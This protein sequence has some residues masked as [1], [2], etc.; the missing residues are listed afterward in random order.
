MNSRSIGRTARMTP[1]TIDAEDPS[2]SFF[3]G[4][5][6][7]PALLARRAELTPWA[8]AYFVQHKK[9]AWEAITWSEAHERVVALAAGLAQRGLRP[10]SRV[11]I[12]AA[13]SLDW[14]IAQMATLECG[15]IVIGIDP[16]YPDL[17]INELVKELRLTFLLAQDL[18]TLNRIPLTTRLGLQFIALFHHE[19]ESP[20]PDFL[21]LGQLLPPSPRE[22]TQ[23]R[24]QIA[25]ATAPAL[26]VFSSGSTGRP[27][28]ILYTHA[29]IVHACRCILELYPELAREA[30]LVCW[31]PLANLF[32]RMINFCATAKGATTYIVSDPRN[33]MDV[34]PVAKPEVLM[35]VPRFCERVHAGIMQTLQRRPRVARMVE[36]AIKLGSEVRHAQA[37]NLPISPTRRLA[38]TLADR[39]VLS[40]L[41]APFGGKL[42][43]IVSGSAPM[44]R[45]LLDR[46]E[47]IGIPVLE[48]YGATENLVP[49]A[50]NRLMQRKS[51]TVGKPVGDNEV[52]IDADGKVEVRGFGVFLPTLAENVARASAVGKDGFLSTGD[53]G[54]RDQEGFLS[55]RGRSGEAFKNSQGRWVSLPIIEAALRTITGVE[56]A[57]VMRIAGDRLVGVLGFAPD[58]RARAG[59]DSTL[60]LEPILRAQLAH[61][62]QALPAAMRPIAYI[63]VCTGF[64]LAGGELTTNLKLRRAAI[65]KRVSAELG[66]LIAESEGDDGN[67]RGQIRLTFA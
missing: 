39:L 29:Q 44:P 3:A 4:V 9:G 64:S 17:L 20:H 50:A 31:L 16:Y 63:V 37:E 59:A 18:V 57:A 24:E 8:P 13:T 25:Q 40:R 65:A 56:H 66:A 28:P 45:W 55:L 5:A 19:T 67:A 52:R 41:R 30:R 32:Q 42:R 15:A 46:M 14:E 51:G 34:L 7:V 22:G 47:A 60:Q 27:Q 21:T 49:I 11:G 54:Y 10:G 48:A 36:A 38:F 26:I 1:F 35:A 2:A 62:V 43:F 33:V 53:I 58:A 12:L 6:T 23:C 61:A